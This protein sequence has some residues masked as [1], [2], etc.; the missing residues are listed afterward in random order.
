MQ[1]LVE[2]F[3]STEQRTKSYFVPSNDPTSDL[4]LDFVSKVANGYEEVMTGNKFYSLKIDFSNIERV[5][6]HFSNTQLESS[7]EARSV[8]E[9]QLER[10]TRDKVCVDRFC[11]F[12][13]SRF[14]QLKNF[15]YLVLLLIRRYFLCQVNLMAELEQAKSQI[16]EHA[17]EIT[18]VS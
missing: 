1:E 14:A 16:I 13:F 2:S 11:L 12:I 15:F 3:P 18:Q 8:L 5:F 9:N 7:S 17:S 6:F 4:A 10:L